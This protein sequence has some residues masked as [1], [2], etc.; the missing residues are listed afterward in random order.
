MLAFG[1]FAGCPKEPVPSVVATNPAE[2]LARAQAEVASGPVYAQ[3]SAVV[4]TPDSRFTA[5][6][7]LV[8]SPPN[9]FR[10][11]LRG[12]IG[13]P[14]L[15][16]TCD[17]TAVRAYLAPKNTF[18]E[19]LDAS[20]ALGSL[21]GIESIDGATVA[22]SL[23]LGRVPAM[24]GSPTVE[25]SSLVWTRFDGARVALSLDQATAH[26]TAV[27]AV[28]ADGTRRLRA[29]WTPGTFPRALH[30]ELPTLGAAADLSFDEWHVASPTDAA[31]VLAAPEGSKRVPIRLGQPEIGSQPVPIPVG[32]APDGKPPEP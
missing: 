6:G 2:A 4:V 24:P 21:W 13:P 8:V 14:Q 31:F 10:I 27:D 9:R 28:A 1:L 25:G 16:V 3:F 12:P 23:L 15:V 11:E 18:Y 5:V 22:T 30:A 26:L 29:D 7:T 19:S 17:G 32:P 20:S